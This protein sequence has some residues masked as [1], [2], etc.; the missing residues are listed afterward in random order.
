[1]AQSNAEGA[2]NTFN[3]ANSSVTNLAGSGSIYH[4]E[5]AEKPFDLEKFKKVILFLAANPVSTQRSRLDEEVR[6]IEAG[7]QRSKHRDRFTLKQQWAVRPR[8][9]Q[10]AMLDHQPQIVHFA[11]HGAG[12][13]LEDNMGQ[14]Q[15]VTTEALA[16]MFSLFAD[17]L[18]CVVMSA[19]YL[20]PQA[21]AI[22]RHIPYVIG[23]NRAVGDGSAI[24][25]AVGF[26]DAL[27]AG[28]SV[29]FAY[30]L[31]CSMIQLSGITEQATPAIQRQLS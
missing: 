17:S 11:G 18:E 10:R 27:G 13:T 26:Y 8:D 24:E 29:E 19:C 23:M 3:I 1:M 16:A 4:T 20:Q 22:A 5:A 7:L 2:Q 25:F 12:L 31:G 6:E 30:K 28:E 9:L 21:Q 14:P 15:P